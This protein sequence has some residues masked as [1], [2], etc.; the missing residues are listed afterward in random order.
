[1]RNEV[2]HRRRAARSGGS[3]RIAAFALL[4]VLTGVGASQAGD[5]GILDPVTLHGTTGLIN[6][7]VADVLPSGTIAFGVSVIDKE[8]AYHGRIQGKAPSRTDNIHYFLTAG[9]LPRVEVSV[10]ASYFPDDRLYQD[11]LE[12]GTVDRGASGRILVLPEG[13]AHPAVAVGGDDVRGTRRFHALYVVG[14]KTF[15]V[16][17]GWVKAR[18]SAGYGS[19]ALD[20]ENYVLDGGFGGGEV[21]LSDF[22]SLALDYDTEKWNTLVRLVAFRHLAARFALLNFEAPAGGLTW[23]HSF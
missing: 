17:P 12:T 15:D 6:T 8:W 9:F 13:K 1:M 2:L 4:G 7:P 3:L 18:I 22:L 20:A 21:V 23:T 5:L 10:R 19:T 16:R 14:S 11:A